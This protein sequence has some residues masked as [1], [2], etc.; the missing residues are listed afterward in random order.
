MCYKTTYELNSFTPVTSAFQDCTK[1]TVDLVFLFDGS[2]SMS[3]MEFK[4]NKSFIKHIMNSLRN[5]TIKFAAVQFSSFHRTVFNFNDD[6]AGTAYKKLDQENHMKELTNTYTALQFVLND[7]LENPKAGASPDA[8]KVLVLI[9]DGDPTDPYKENGIIDRYVKKGIIRFVIAVKTAKLDA[10]TA[11]SSQ[12]LE[13]YAFKIEHYV[14]L[15]DIL[16]RFQKKIFKMEGS[17]VARAGDM[18]NELSQSG[19]SV[20]YYNGTLILGSVGS[21][22]WSG[23]LQ[24]H[25]N[26]KEIQIEDPH[27]QNDSYMGYSLSVG[28]R[29]NTPIYFTGAPRFKHL[30]QV[31]LFRHDGREWKTAQ[32]VNGDQIGSYFG[33][34]L[35]SVDIDLNGDTD[36]LLVGA[37]MF[38]H[39]TEKG[40]GQ[41]YVYALTNEIQLKSELNIKATS[42]GR[43]GTT[44]S[45]LADLNGDGLTDV[46]IGAPLDDDSRG[47]VY[48]FLGDRQ[49][50]IRSTFSQR[51]R[52]QDIDPGLKFFGQAVDGGIDLGEDGLTDIVIGSQGAAVVLRSRPVFNVLAHLSFL[53]EEISTER[54]DCVANTDD[55]LPMGNLTACFQMVE[56]TNCKAEAMSAGLNISYIV[57]VDPMR[58]TYRGFFK[59]DKKARNFTSYVNLMENKVCY[60][61]TIA[62][63]KCVKDTLTP[64]SI[65]LNF[66]Q[67]DSESASNMLNVDSKNQAVVEIPFERQCAKHD[68]CIAELDVDFDFMT[69]TLYV[70]ED[71]YFNL[72]IKLSN[73][74][75]DSYNTSLMMYYPPG[76]SFSRLTLTQA[77]RQTLHSCNDLE[78]VL[79]KTL[80]GISRPVYRG[81][82][83]ATFQSSFYIITDYEWNDTISVTVTGRS[84]N[85]NITTNNTITKVIPVQLEIKMA[86]T[87]NEGSTTYL[88][89][90]TDDYGPKKVEAIYK[91]ANLGLKAFPVNVSL[92]LPTKLEHD[93]EMMDYHV[94]VRQNK[95]TCSLTDI[96][97]EY[98]GMPENESKVIKCDTFV[99]EKESSAEFKLSG[100]VHFKDLK[101]KAENIAFL[102]RYTG[103]SG[104]VKFRSF[105]HVQYDQ[106]RYA[107]DSRE[108]K[109]DK[110]MHHK[111]SSLWTS[112]DPTWKWTEVRVEFIIPLH[113]MTII[114]TGVGVGL[115]LIIILTVIMLKLGCF[116]RK[117][118]Y[119]EEADGDV[120]E[121]DAPCD[122]DPT[123]SQSEIEENK[124][125]LLDDE[126][127]GSIQMC[128]TQEK[129]LE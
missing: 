30:G 73:R 27:M 3:E 93:F 51:I 127:N 29:D 38:Y 22:T 119:G 82:S 66:S 65:K 43:L 32:R 91:V 15:T 49:K 84:D 102:K 100:Q 118:Y 44:I 95:T 39:P 50:G 81:Q 106:R 87:V 59:S 8:T 24:E 7:I 45:S 105:I 112:K 129:M 115:F 72:S 94:S 107:L 114:L 42:V 76:L 54:F 128:D 6:Q 111:I 9:T 33:A 52:G 61:Y 37:P 86:I 125:G 80:C 98:Y 16:E 34:E 109:N 40:E 83:A 63:M 57:N 13:K 74:G 56:T 70:A 2:N 110:L 123:K 55:H 88:N 60:N 103:E 28:K 69:P 36:F 11:I 85:A 126:K 12:P 113:Q 97:S 68:T 20:V 58:Q 14:G 99:L 19:C 62:M 35:C 96:K 25:S 78:G 104:E 21:H 101:K 116:K 5:T 71:N 1:K 67:V 117:K 31:V 48:I 89:F 23:S 77:T 121:T 120:G 90:T 17:S 79:D 64:I 18:T 92:F 46:A 108:Q 4:E 53:P 75:D 47:V 122:P 41:V 124:R 26:N 10:F